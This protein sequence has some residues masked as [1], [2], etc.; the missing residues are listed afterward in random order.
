MY[1]KTGD[2]AAVI[3][4]ENLRWVS[5]SAVIMGYDDHAH[6]CSV[7]RCMCTVW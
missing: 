1:A 6:T 4:C 5:A 2:A 7:L 3:V